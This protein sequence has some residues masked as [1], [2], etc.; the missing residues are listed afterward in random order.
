M[1]VGSMSHVCDGCSRDGLASPSVHKYQ[2]IALCP[3]FAV[4]WCT[5]TP[6]E[7]VEEAWM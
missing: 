3:A 7:E 1:I 4:R 6:V 2:K 5:L